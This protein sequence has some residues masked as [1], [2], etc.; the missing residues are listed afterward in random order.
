MSGRSGTR[1]EPGD[2]R[3]A[4][5]AEMRYFGGYTDVE[6]AETLG[7]TDRT[8]RSD[9]ERARLILKEALR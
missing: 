2:D 3:L 9:W 6:I 4:V 7:V 8:V 1:R 5:V